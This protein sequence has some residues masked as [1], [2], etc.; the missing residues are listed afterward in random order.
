M[1]LKIDPYRG[2]FRQGPTSFNNRQNCIRPCPWGNVSN[3]RAYTR[4][5]FLRVM[6]GNSM[7]S[8]IRPNLLRISDQAIN[9]LNAYI[10]TIARPIDKRSSSLNIPIL[11]YSLWHQC[12][13]T[14]L[15]ISAVSLAARGLSEIY[16]SNNLRNTVWPIVI[17]FVAWNHMWL[18][19]ELQKSCCYNVVKRLYILCLIF[20]S[21]TNT[22][23]VPTQYKI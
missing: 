8:P 22:L 1:E 23:Y 18:V 13:L 15:L 16:S 2:R 5:E 14:L 3:S 17:Q 11:Q 7:N 4:R 19:K 21:K 9:S 6:M 12:R 20:Q 10:S